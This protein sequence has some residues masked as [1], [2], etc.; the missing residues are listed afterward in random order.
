MRS[1]PSVRLR[2]TLSANVWECLRGDTS[3]GSTAARRATRGGRAVGSGLPFEAHMAHDHSHAHLHAGP[4]TRPVLWRVLLLNLTLLVAEVVVGLT[5]GSLA[6]LSDAGHMLGDV[7]ALALALGA[8]WLARRPPNPQQTFGM[9][10]AEVMG[11][12][13]NGATMLVVIVLIV[14]EAAHRL[15]AGAPDVPG[16]PVLVIGVVGLVINLLSALA[17]YRA[18]RHNLSIRG[19][20]LHMVADALGSLEA[21]IAALCLLAGLPAADALASLAVAVLVGWSTLRLLR[22][23]TRVLLQFAPPGMPV[24][25]VRASL[26]ALEAVSEVHALHIWTIDGRQPVVS[27]HLVDSEGADAVAL[28]RDANALLGARFG[29]RDSTIQIESGDGCGRGPQGGGDPLP[30]SGD[31]TD[32]AHQG[33]DHGHGH[34]HR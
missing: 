11:A 25:Q 7:G 9:K 10:R 21:I 14:L 15:A 33:H 30:P 17:L 32:S 20:L 18:D 28:T 6:V 4:D 19:A 2:P 26:E 24:E 29:V 23:T 5:T 13:V 12:L 16:M 3:D 1:T 31:P 34:A 27:A 8:A 22:E